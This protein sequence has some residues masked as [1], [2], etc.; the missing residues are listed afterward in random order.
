[1]FNFRSYI[2]KWCSVL[3]F[4]SSFLMVSAQNSIDLM[5]FSSEKTKTLYAHVKDSQAENDALF[6]LFMQ[7]H[8]DMS[9]GQLDSIVNRVKALA[10]TISQDKKYQKRP[11]KRA[12]IIHNA[13]H[14]R[15]FKKYVLNALP[16]ML[17]SGRYNCVTATAYVYFLAVEL[18]VEC[19]IKEEPQHVYPVLNIGGIEY[20]IETTDISKGYTKYP[21]SYKYE[22]VEQLKQYKFIGTDEYVGLS[23]EEIFERLYERK[24][25]INFRDLLALQYSNQGIFNIQDQDFKPAIENMAKAYQLLPDDHVEL[26]FVSVLIN[27]LNTSDFTDSASVNSMKMLAQFAQPKY[28]KDLVLPIY[29]RFILQTMIESDRRALF[30]NVSSY[31]MSHISDTLV[32]K[33]FEFINAVGQIDYYDAR[34]DFSK[35]I[36][37]SEKALNQKSDQLQLLGNYISLYRR[38]FMAEGIN[39]D[40]LNT[41]IEKHNSYPLLKDL[42]DYKLLVIEGLRN[43]IV[44]QV[45]QRKTNASL[46]WLKKMEDFNGVVGGNVNNLEVSKVYHAVS[47]LCFENERMG[48]AYRCINKAIEFDPNNSQLRKLKQ[49]YGS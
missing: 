23:N 26:T 28:L 12:E 21:K 3:C 36:E 47:L 43:H 29:G 46:Q 31:Y 16:E 27:V 48:D 19:T 18:N 8:M 20:P 10:I 1:M 15:V 6:R 38:K 25:S 24:R 5:E 37:I 40:N 45:R 41:L 33:E 49:L 39:N 17:D 11:D 32:L 42:Y 14:D 9:D 44:D 7:T 2:F 22:V 13:V 35:A 4:S 34:G 30:D